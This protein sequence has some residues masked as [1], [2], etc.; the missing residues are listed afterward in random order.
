MAANFQQTDAAAAAGALAAHCSGNSD[1]TDQESNQ[2]DVGG[3]AG[4]TERT[5]TADGSAADLNAIWME[6]GNGVSIDTYDGGAGNWTIRINIATSNHQISLD[7]IHICRV[8]S[9]YVNQETLGSLTGI[10]ENW[11]STGTKTHTVNQAAGTTIDP[12][13]KI[14]IIFAIDNGNAM[15][16]N[17]GYTPSLIIDA[18]GSFPSAGIMPQARAAF[19]RVF[20][21]VF[22]RVNY[23]F[24]MQARGQLC[25]L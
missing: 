14:L 8:N 18:P 2:A 6:L 25:T 17:F 9:S 10:G 23:E 12:G 16:Q 1:N 3:A 4:S 20:S 7:E 13:D 5:V 24:P 22:G 11:G 19:R 15:T 21:R